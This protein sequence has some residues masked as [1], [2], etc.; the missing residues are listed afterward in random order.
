MAKTLVLAIVIGLLTLGSGNLHAQKLG[1]AEIY[2]GVNYAVAQTIAQENNLIA[3]WRGTVETPAEAQAK[4]QRAEDE[5]EITIYIGGVSDHERTTGR[6]ESYKQ[7]N[8]MV[9]LNISTT[10]NWYGFR[11]VGR[12]VRVFDNSR[13]GTTDMKGIGI[14]WCYELILEG[15]YS[16]IK[17]YASITDAKGNKISGWVPKPIPTLSLG[18][19]PY[20]VLLTPIDKDTSFI[21]FGYRTQVNLF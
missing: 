19:G 14:E 1:D 5:T 2:P 7:K 9:G 4:T 11:P 17:A 12:W 15:C 10:E 20:L 18:K 16:Q 8:P 13:K 21:Y 3:R 6:K